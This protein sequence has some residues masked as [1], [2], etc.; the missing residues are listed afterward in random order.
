M[1]SP[2]TQLQQRMTRSTLLRRA[3]TAAA[4]ATVTGTMPAYAFAGPLKYTRR[5]LK[6]TLTIVQWNHVVPAY[7]TWLDT[8]AAAWGEEN[9]VEVEIDHVDYTRLPSLAA[10]EVKAQKGHDIFGFLS[11]PAS[12]AD[13]VI[14]HA[15]IVSEVERR[16]GSYGELGRKST[17]DPRRKRYFG[18][19]DAYVP[20]PTIWRHDLWNA[21]GESPATWDHVRAAAPI[22]KANGH[23]IGIG[24]SPELDSTAALLGLLMCFGSTLQDET[25][26]LTIESKETVDA[27]QFMADLY[28]AG[29]D[30]DVFD[31]TPTS[32]NR[33]LLSGKGSLIVNAIS[34]I[35]TADNLQLP[36]ADDLWL[37]PIPT[38]PGGRIAPAQYTHVYSIWSFAKNTEA[39]EKFIADLCT[40]SE[41]AVLA[42]KLFQYPS[43]P[44]AFPAKKLY[45]AAAADTTPPKGKYTILTTIASTHTRN[46]GYPGHTTAAVDETLRT[47]LLPRMFAQVS[48]GKLSARESVRA[49]AY[50]MKKIW[51]RQRHADG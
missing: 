19:S 50:E 20:A 42:S 4:I 44:G 48:Q 45:Q 9:D 10:A 5:S 22:L 18:V 31:W 38:G 32:N 14:D 12:Y 36:F 28:R 13:Q 51:R 47:F 35:R 34:A 2:Q 40:A 7:D 39:A 16:V 3:G 8:W 29:Q 25:G 1:T 17:Y 6:G 33:L 24:Q 37:W 26:T 49:T 27:V 43:F 41:K 11:P 15:D 23:P 21:I 46:L 30:S